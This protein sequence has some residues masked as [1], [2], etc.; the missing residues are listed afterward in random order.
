MEQKIRLRNGYLQ[1]DFD[2]NKNGKYDYVIIAFVV[3]VF[4]CAV[5]KLLIL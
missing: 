4:V 1:P 2:P 3:L 5:A